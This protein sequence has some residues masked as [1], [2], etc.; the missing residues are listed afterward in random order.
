MQLC[1]L[2]LKYLSSPEDYKYFKDKTKW[3][4]I[5]QNYIDPFGK[6]IN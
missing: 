5:G 3:V 2:G 4:M 6:L 1:P